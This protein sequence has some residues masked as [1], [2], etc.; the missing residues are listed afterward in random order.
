MSARI[1]PAQP[2]FDAAVQARLD[3][4]MPPGV[5]PLTLF[6][7]LARDGRLF[8]RFMD[9]GLLDRGHLTMRQREVVI[10]RV[11]AQCG[12]EYEWGV[13]IIYFAERVGLTAEQQASFRHGGPKDGC[14]S[15]EDGL[16]LRLC[17]A[18]AET[19][20][21]DDDLWAELR[22][23]FSEEAVIELILLAGFYRTTSYLVNALRLP[24]EA[25]AA[26][27]PQA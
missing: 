13:H 16:L 27:F 18:L 21:I 11:T 10:D 19:C 25:T 15:A 24:L 9:G 20:D 23:A 26:R 6:T 2:P 22:G 4:V 7:T 14:W 5:P 8:K 3:A 12:A 1:S 17:D